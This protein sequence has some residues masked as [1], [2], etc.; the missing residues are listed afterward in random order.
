[1]PINT[2]FTFTVADFDMSGH[3]SSTQLI[4]TG[5]WKSAGAITFVAS[6]NNGPPDSTIVSIAGTN[7]PSM[8]SFS[9]TG[10]AFTSGATTANISYA[11]AVGGQIKF[12][13]SATKGSTTDNE[14][15]DQTVTFNNF[16]AFG[17]LPNNTSFSSANITTLY[18]ANNDLTNST[19]KTITGFTVGSGEFFAYAYRDAISDPS[20]VRCG[21]GANTLTVAMN[22]S[23]A[24]QKTPAT[25]QV[26]SYTNAN[27][28]SENYRVIGSKIADITDHSTTIVISTSSQVKNYFFWGR[29]SNT[30]QENESGVEG[31][32][33]KSSTPDDGTITDPT[34]L[35]VGILS[36]QYI[37]IA[38]PS[39][40]GAN[41]TNYQLKDNGTNLPL[42]VNSPVNVDITNPVGFQE[43][44]KVYRSINQLD[45][46]GNSFTVKIDSV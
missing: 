29:N 37:Y 25:T 22:P 31:L 7:A 21:T 17:S 40:Y 42:D 23:D 44:Y 43:Q 8:T 20:T 45:S 10:P 12:N 24:T 28:F 16:R 33:N 36:G 34:T 26:A 35:T 2:T 18:N 13:L 32:E 5:T 3:G 27:S 41:G 38:I 11:T 4:G 46:L 9:L 14:N 30:G 15:T 19:S 39:R 1:V 6:Y